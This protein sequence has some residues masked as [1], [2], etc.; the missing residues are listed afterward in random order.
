MFKVLF[1]FF[2]ERSS[3][4]E[5]LCSKLCVSKFT[6]MIMLARLQYAYSPTSKKWRRKRIKYF[7]SW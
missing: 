4:V 5:I 1:V 2:S 7:G 6:G 3:V